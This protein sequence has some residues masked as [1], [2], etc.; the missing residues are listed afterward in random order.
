MT[1]S[2]VTGAS[3]GIGFAIALRLAREGHRVHASV[4]S[5][6]RGQD[7]LEAAAGHDLSLVVMDV[8]D[9]DSVAAG[10]GGVLESTGRIDVLVNNAGMTL[11]HDIESTPVSAFRQV[12]N[13]NA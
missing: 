11:G 7:L 2:V 12:M 5:Q 8:D 10:L 13:T 6:A 1:V 4:R 3:T 9:D